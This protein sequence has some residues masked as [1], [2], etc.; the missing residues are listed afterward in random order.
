MAK[1]LKS[2]E[3]DFRLLI[4]GKGPDKEK[5]D[6]LISKYQLH[7]NV[8][9][10]GH[11]NPEDFFRNIDL[12]VFSSY[13]EGSANALIESL[14]N[15]VPVIAFDT[16]SNPEIVKDGIN[17]YLVPLYDEKELASK[18][19]S[20]ANSNEL[21]LEMQS[22]AHKTIE[23]LFNYTEKVIEVEGLI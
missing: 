1:I 3:I 9:L 6:N 8:Y 21:Y 13:F 12:F 19:I 15:H 23:E 10:E 18:V 7:E 5:L 20:I 11:V 22:Q 4:G 16:S 14:Q 2:K 17:G